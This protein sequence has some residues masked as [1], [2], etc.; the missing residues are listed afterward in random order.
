MSPIEI[1]EIQQIV[2]SNKPQVRSST[3]HALELVVVV[4]GCLDY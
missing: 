3:I 4:F 1:E 2:P